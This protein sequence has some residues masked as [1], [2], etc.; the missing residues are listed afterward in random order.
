MENKNRHI[1][2]SGR[3]LDENGELDLDELVI[4]L[5]IGPKY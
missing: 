5:V 2:L 1:G 4:V 3:N